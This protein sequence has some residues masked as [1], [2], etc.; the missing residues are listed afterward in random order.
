M[1]LQHLLFCMLLDSFVP[2]TKKKK[3]ILC[4]YFEVEPLVGPDT[5][6]S[7]LFNEVVMETAREPGSW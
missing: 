7:A 1:H 4:F 6:G 5:L 2:P 3:H